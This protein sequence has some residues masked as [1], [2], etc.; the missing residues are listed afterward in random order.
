[1]TDSKEIQKVEFAIN[2]LV[3]AHNG[4]IYFCDKIF[5]DYWPSHLSFKDKEQGTKFTGATGTVC[6]IITEAEIKQRIAD[7]DFDELWKMAVKDGHYTGS[8]E[9]YRAEIENNGEDEALAFED[10]PNRCYEAYTAAGLTLADNEKLETTGG[11]RC[12]DVAEMIEMIRHDEA[13]ENYKIYDREAFR[14]IIAAEYTIKQEL[15]ELIAFHKIEA[16]YAGKD[17]KK[18]DHAAAIIRHATGLQKILESKP[19]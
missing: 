5:L 10:A 15:N 8:L 14:A 7:Y 12:F 19:R 1:M 13:Y 2:K 3:Y 11:G 4:D 17:Q 16:S 6:Q 9:D 18:R